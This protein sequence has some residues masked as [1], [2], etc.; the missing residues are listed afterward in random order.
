M[1]STNDFRKGLKIEMEGVPFAIVEYQF[2]SPGKGGAFVR[3]KLRN[4]LNG[5]VIEKTFK[6]GD[7]V[8]KADLE[9]FEFQY[10][11]KEGE[12]FVFMN[13]TNYE[14]T[15]LDESML[16]RAK[17]FLKENTVIQI[18]FHNGRP[19]G[20]DLPTFVELTIAR[21]EPGFKGD[22]ATNASKPATLETG[23]VITVP[24]HIKEGDM[25]KVDTR[26]F[27]YSE[28]VNR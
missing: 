18:L 7:K 13:N 1:F 23:G 17:D 25:V 9:Q 6:S 16:G 10:L 3:T 2:V 4:M 22:T 20:L 26:D 21:T 24:L 15:H 12:H 11:Y 14:Q 5:N 8:D 27:S 28:K 19:I